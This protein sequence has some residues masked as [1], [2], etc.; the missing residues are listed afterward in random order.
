M[1]AVVFDKTGTLTHGALVV[2]ETI[3]VVPDEVSDAELLRLAASAESQSEHLIGRAIVA[4][5]RSHGVELVQPTGAKAVAGL[6]FVCSIDGAT[7]LLGN[8]RCR[9]VSQSYTTRTA[10]R[11]LTGSRPYQGT[12]DG[13]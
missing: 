2:T 3:S 11:R 9:S 7:I 5:A 4:H 6:G 8:R 1:S 10:G 13:S 12:A